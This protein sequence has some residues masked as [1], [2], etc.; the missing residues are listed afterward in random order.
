MTRAI[1]DRSFNRITVD[2]DTSTNDSFI[3]MATGQSS[4]RVDSVSDP[5][6][7]PLYEALAEAAT[8]LAQKI[9]RDAEGATKFMTIQ[10]EQAKTGEEALKVAYAVA[11]SPLVKPAFFASDPNLDRILS[12]IEIGSESCR[13]SV[14]TN[15]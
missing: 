4:V 11:Q 12:A 9:V 1:A 2:G 6:Y 15:G 13:E 5:L 8:E 14:G 7:T 3:I 10:V